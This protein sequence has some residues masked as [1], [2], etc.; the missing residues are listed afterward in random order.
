MKLTKHFTLEEL[1]ASS[2][3]KRLNISNKPTNEEIENMKLN[4]PSIE[5]DWDDVYGD[6]MQKIVFIGQHMDVEEI[7]K[8][9]DSCIA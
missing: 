8:M 6:K 5:R 7:K 1:C 2:T 3:A 4:D 9:L